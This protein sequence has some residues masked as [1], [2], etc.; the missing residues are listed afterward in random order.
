[1]KYKY[2]RPIGNFY[3]VS[4][5]KWNKLYAKRGQWPFGQVHLY[6]SDDYAV[7]QHVISPVGY[8]AYALTFLAV[9]PY[10]ILRYGFMSAV[11]GHWQELNYKRYGNFSEDY[12]YR[13][14]KSDSTAVNLFTN[15]KE[16]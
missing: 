15:G 1:M 7:A 16:W 2:K 5:K 8:L 10:H 11:N 13:S 9:L 3:R 14:K 6:V 4:Y 12:F